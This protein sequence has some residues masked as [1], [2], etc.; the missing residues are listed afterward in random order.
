MAE[1]EELNELLNGAVEVATERL[2]ADTEFLP[3]AL[4]MQTED[5][6]VFH[7]E[8]DEEDLSDGEDQGLIVAAL[9]SGLRDAAGEGRWKAVA[10]VADV[11]VE[12]EDGQAVTSAIQIWLE[13]VGTEAISC[14]IPYEI[15]DDAVELAELV[16]EPGESTVFA[17]AAAPN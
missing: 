7:L 12:D 8:P 10:I 5:D 17:E 11:T 6:E 14:T 15:G 9:R 4:A 3:F 13:H 2:A 16:A 1:R